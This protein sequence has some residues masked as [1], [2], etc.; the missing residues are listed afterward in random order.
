MKKPENK[1]NET[2]NCLEVTSFEVTRA[3]YVEGK[4][5]K[6]GFA[7]FDLILNGISIYGMKALEGKNGDF[8]SFPQHA[9]NDG[10]YY[11]TAW[12]RLSDDDQK[13]IIEAVESKLNN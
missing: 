9:G 3:N 12:A 1:T 2:Q 5:G 4:N 10:K 7:F 11:S 8:I 6:K 13:K